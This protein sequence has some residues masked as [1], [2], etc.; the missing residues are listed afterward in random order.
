MADNPLKS[1]AD[2]RAHLV[3]LEEATFIQSETGCKIH[4]SEIG[5]I[6]GND[7]AFIRQAEAA[8]RESCDQIGDAS[9]RQFALMM[10]GGEQHRES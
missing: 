6:A 3:A 9:E 7:P 4:K 10:A 2:V 8:R 1:F 5:V